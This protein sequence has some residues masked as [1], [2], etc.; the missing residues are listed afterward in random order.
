MAIGLATQR[1]G[2]YGGVLRR[3][4]PWHSRAGLP[5]PGRDGGVF[6]HFTVLGLSCPRTS[7]RGPM[8]SV[9]SGGCP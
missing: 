3:V 2:D 4:L 7:L 1:L 6:V 5:E 9:C 8:T